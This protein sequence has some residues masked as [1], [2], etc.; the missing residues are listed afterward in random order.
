M[1]KLL[2]GN[3]IYLSF[4]TEIELLSYHKLDPSAENI[5][6][7]FLDNCI[8]FDLN[9]EI[10]E[11]TIEIRKSTNLKLPDSFIASTAYFLNIPLLTADMQVEKVHVIDLILYQ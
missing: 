5:I 9:Q 7:K 6:K 8:V 1:Q 3:K 10:K 4:I 2:N 11:L